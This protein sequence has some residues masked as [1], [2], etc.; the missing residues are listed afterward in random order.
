M[1]SFDQWVFPLFSRGLNVDEL[2]AVQTLQ[3]DGESVSLASDKM[4]Q[5]NL[6]QN[7]VT[8]TAKNITIFYKCTYLNTHIFITVSQKEHWLR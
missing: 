8:Y 7:K 4:P 2:P 5:P 1:G 3:G 6:H